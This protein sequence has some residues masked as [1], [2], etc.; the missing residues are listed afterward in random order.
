VQ[1]NAISRLRGWDEMKK[2]IKRIIAFVSFALVTIGIYWYVIHPNSYRYDTAVRNGDVVMGAGGLANV[3]KF[4]T[5]IANVKNKQPDKIRITAYSKEGYPE[6]F[7]LDYNGRIIKCTSDN[8]RNLFGRDNFKKYGEY[9]KILKNEIN[10]YFLVDE[11]GKY[12]D[13]WI[14]QE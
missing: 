7:D 6:I 5:F 14:F 12:K 10:Y 11:S 13:L 4:H 3:E 8:T 2:T 9:T 1:F